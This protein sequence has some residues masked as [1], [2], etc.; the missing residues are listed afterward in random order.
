MI[1]KLMENK[2]FQWGSIFG[3][4]LLFDYSE[5]KDFGDY[6]VFYFGGVI[7]SGTCIAI[8]GFLLSYIEESIRR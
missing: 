8:G 5:A 4:P 3:L 6:C 1:A 2:W 7:V